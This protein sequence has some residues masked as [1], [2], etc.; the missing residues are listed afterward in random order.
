MTQPTWL[1][2]CYTQ[3]SS[4]ISSMLE[5]LNEAIVH[6]EAFYSTKFTKGNYIIIHYIILY[7]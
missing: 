4:D 1:H 2:G 6:N 7:S 5:P 3:I